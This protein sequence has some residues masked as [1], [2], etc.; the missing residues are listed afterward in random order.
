MENRQPEFLQLLTFVILTGFLIWRGS[1]ESRD[2]QDE[3]M[4]AIRRIEARLDSQALSP[5]D[6]VTVASSGNGL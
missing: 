6:P 5:E 4:E 2:G 1:P 3:M